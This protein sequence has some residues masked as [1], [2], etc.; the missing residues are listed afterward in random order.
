MTMTRSP[1]RRRDLFLDG[2]TISPTSSRPE[3]YGSSG[4]PK[5]KSLTNTSISEN[6]ELAN[7]GWNGEWWGF[8]LRCFPVYGIESND[9]VS[10]EEFSVI[11]YWGSRVV[12]YLF[13]RLP[14]AKENQGTLLGRYTGSRWRKGRW[15]RWRFLDLFDGNLEGGVFSRMVLDSERLN[16][17]TETHGLIVKEVCEMIASFSSPNG[18]KTFTIWDDTAGTRTNH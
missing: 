17:S 11:K 13:I 7:S 4:M 16:Q 18:S 12:W 6:Q 9:S 1:G 5:L 15:C 2:T 10:D 3:T 8:L 14:R